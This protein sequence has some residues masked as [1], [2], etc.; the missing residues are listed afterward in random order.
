MKKAKHKKNANKRN[1]EDVI[2]TASVTAVEA[3]THH[4]DEPPV[5]EDTAPPVDPVTELQERIA[6]LEDA[7]LRAKADYQNLQ[8][9]S[10]TQQADAVRYA[11]AELMKSLI[12]VADDFD[13]AIAASDGT[14]DPE[15]MINGMKLVYDNFT[16]ALQGH[17]LEY[18]PALHEAF[19]PALHEALLHQPTDA[20]DPNIVVEEVAKGY[21]LRDRVIRPAKVVVSK[22][23]DDAEENN[24]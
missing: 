10:A 9:R 17:G 14:D 12:A 6:S 23:K 22:A 18:V 15:A 16:K 7:L 24:T 5:A 21:R 3:N 11:N 4:P 19:D 1:T 20:H 8:R 2:E 13:R